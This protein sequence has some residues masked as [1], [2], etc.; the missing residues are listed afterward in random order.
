MASRSNKLKLCFVLPNTGTRN[1]G[2][3][4]M[5]A[6]DLLHHL[7]PA[8]YQLNLVCFEPF[9]AVIP[10][11]DRSR[12]TIDIVP[13]GPGTEPMQV[14]RLARHFLATR[15]HL[16]H[17]FNEGA[18]IYAFP[19]AKLARVPVLVHAEH[20]RRGVPERPIL[21][22]VRIAFTR[23]A[24]HV[25][26]V[27]A[28]LLRVLAQQE[29]IPESTVTV[30]INGV[31]TAKFD[32]P[33]D[34]NAYRKA[35]GIEPGDWVVGTVGALSERKNQRLLILA[36]RSLPA[37]KVLIAG[38]GPLEGELR[39]LIDA[40]GVGD[41]VKLVGQRDDV[42]S[43]VRSLDVFALPSKIEGTSLA[44]LEAMAARRAVLATDVGGSAELVVSGTTGMLVLSEDLQQIVDRLGWS[45]DHRDEV[46]RMGQAG[47]ARVDAHF[48][49]AATARA[50]E[51]VFLSALR[52]KG[53]TAPA[54]APTPWAS[55]DVDGLDDL[56]ENDLRRPG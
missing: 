18:L 27:S 21:R 54:T 50:Y 24:D 29:G 51:E 8:R 37:I 30:I 3:M 32:E 26:A 38:A 28:D 47:R 31:A 6:A 46:E 45:F 9:N 44:I 15:P 5:V 13:K 10:R 7:D 33:F 53:V 23:L 36:A 52:R 41:R 35:F 48:S 55:G 39:A 42:P 16:I 49:F 25:T 43:F 34:R 1:I 4:E 20:G 19:A 22:R 2:G 11:I 17:T 40:L 56:R 14:A 12:V